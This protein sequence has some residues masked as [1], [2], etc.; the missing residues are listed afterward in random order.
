MNNMWKLTSAPPQT[1]GITLSSTILQNELKRNLPPG[2]VAQFPNGAE[3]AYAAIPKIHGLKEPLRS[4]IR[5]AF[6]K[7]MSTV[8]LMMVGFSGLGVLTLL[9]LREVPLNRYTDETY[10]LVEGER[11]AAASQTTSMESKA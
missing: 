4:E 1:W 5:Q 7:S 3:I 8:W 10:G 2:F 9:L 11:S 6:S